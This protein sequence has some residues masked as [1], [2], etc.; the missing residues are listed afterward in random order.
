MLIWVFKEW[1]RLC[2]PVGLLLAALVGA[3]VMYI[4]VP[5]YEATALLMIE[6]SPQFIAFSNSS[7]GQSQR[8]VQTQLELMRDPVV[9]ERVLS[10]PEIASIPELALSADRVETLRKNLSVLPRRG[11]ELYNISYTSPIP[12]QAAT[13][14]NAVADEYMEYHRN[15][16]SQRTQRVIDL[17]EEERRR[18]AIEVERLR[19]RVVSLT[20]EA[21][22]KDP[23]SGSLT[24]PKRAANPIGSVVQSL[25]EMDL[26]RE[27]LKAQRQFLEDSKGGAADSLTSSG[28]LTLDVD[29]HP[30]T[31]KRQDIIAELAAQMETVKSDAIRDQRNPKWETSKTYVALQRELTQR[32]Q[33]LADFKKKLRAMILIQ[34]KEEREANCEQ[35]IGKIDRQLAL[36]ETQNSVLTKQFEDQLDKIQSGEGKSVEVE[37]ARAELAREEK[38]FEMIASRKLA[39]QTEMRAPA[40]IQLQRKAVAPMDPIDP[41]PYKVLFLACSAAMCAPFGL[42]LLKEVMVRRISDVDQLAQET[43]MR[44]L[45]EIAELPVRH[46]AIRP[47][48]IAGRIQRDMRVFAESINSLRTNLMLAED[49]QEQHVLAVMSP[50]SSESKTSVATSLA[51]SIA[52]ASGRATLIIDGDMRAPDVATMLKIKSRPGL[53]EVL[54]GKCELEDAIHR[55]GDSQ[56]Y[57]IPSG[58]A[59]RDTCHVVNLKGVDELLNRLRPK[60]GS[61]VIDTP[62]ILGASEA[63]I[64]AKAA[65][66]VLLCSLSGVSKVKQLRL[67]IERLDHAGVNIAGAVLSGS[68]V[69]RY[70]YRYGYYPIENDSGK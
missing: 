68:S 36:L 64:M 49:L 32:Q 14:V 1:W 54:S 44:I 17:L 22:G 37:F 24:D 47:G 69:K 23:F 8:Y 65:D 34:R 48:R 20:E 19:R 39:L 26:Q 59:N 55:V 27:M 46:I 11:S 42:A 7:S 21:T 61:I 12:T 6:E 2:I 18:R 43:R 9:L 16:D 13:V 10:K 29:N 35:E 56:L 60:F 41:L 4:H 51:M 3:A 53:F 70:S 45:G 63:I 38:V 15:D 30:E 67:A 62:P 31:V 5:R 33:D 52:N 40:R 50:A 57:A 28:L 66:A 58:R 25:T